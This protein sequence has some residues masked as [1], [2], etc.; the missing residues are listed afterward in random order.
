MLIW[1][2]I[3]DTL[4]KPEQ[5]FLTNDGKTFALEISVDQKNYPGGIKCLKKMDQPCR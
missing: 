1:N 3:N 5:A 4:N 2:Y